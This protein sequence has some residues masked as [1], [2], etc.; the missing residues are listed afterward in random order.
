MNKPL[1]PLKVAATTFSRL[2]NK[3]VTSILNE[4]LG[5]S[6]SKSN[7]DELEKPYSFTKLTL[8]G[9]A[10]GVSTASY[11]RPNMTVRSSLTNHLSCMYIEVFS[12]SKSA[13]IVPTASCPA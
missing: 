10:I 6:T 3:S 11:L 9:G 13:A 8:V 5:C 4:N 7:F 2:A 1:P 12:T